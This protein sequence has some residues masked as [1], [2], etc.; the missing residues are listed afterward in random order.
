MDIHGL[1]GA[2]GI[3]HHFLRPSTTMLILLVHI[4]FR[5][6]TK[7]RTDGIHHYHVVRLFFLLVIFVPTCF[8]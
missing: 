5:K 8:Q 6:Q 3:H 4:G 1:S 2:T 7:E